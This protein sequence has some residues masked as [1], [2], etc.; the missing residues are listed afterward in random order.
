MDYVAG[1][2]TLLLRA[3]CSQNLLLV[4]RRDSM[5]AAERGNSMSGQQPKLEEK[6]ILIKSLS[7]QL[8]PT[9]PS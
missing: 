8:E 4:K 1:G 9:G 3:V 6:E 2:R 7:Q 5:K